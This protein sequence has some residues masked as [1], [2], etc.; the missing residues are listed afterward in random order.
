MIILCRRCK[1][2]PAPNATPNNPA[3][4]RMCKF[5]ATD[6]NRCMRAFGGDFDFTP[7]STRIWVGKG[8]CPID[9]ALPA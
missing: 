2:F 7:G 6:Y 8:Q 5:C 1:K 3:G 4:Y 9:L